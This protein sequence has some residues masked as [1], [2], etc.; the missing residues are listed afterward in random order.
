MYNVFKTIN[1]KISTYYSVIVSQSDDECS[2]AKKCADCISNADCFWCS[3]AGD[4]YHKAKCFPKSS[5]S[6]KQQCSTFEDP[7]NHVD[8]IK[9]EDI[10]LGK[11]LLC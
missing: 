6:D 9:N 11:K 8:I 4:E 1:I 7:K 3:E 5:E 2:E 10:H